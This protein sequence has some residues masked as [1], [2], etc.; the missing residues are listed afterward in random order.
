MPP[1]YVK[2]IREEEE[3]EELS[4]LLTDFI[5]RNVTNVPFV[6]P[7]NT[8]ILQEFEDVFEST[9]FAGTKDYIAFYG[10]FRQSSRATLEETQGSQGNAQD[11]AAVEF[12]AEL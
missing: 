3:W 7:L 11:E 8:T 1:R 4:K 2:Q 10:M 12:M 9:A 5:G 6:L